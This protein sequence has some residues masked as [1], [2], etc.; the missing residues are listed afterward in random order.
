[1]HGLRPVSLSGRGCGRRVELSGR[2]GTGQLESTGAGTGQKYLYGAGIGGGSDY[3]GIQDG[4]GGHG[5]NV[6]ITGG[7][8]TAKGSENGAGIGGGR[9]GSC[10][11]VTITIAFDANGGEGEM[12]AAQPDENGEYELPESGFTAPEGMEFAGWRIGEEVEQPAEEPVEQPVEAPADA[13]KCTITFDGGGADG[14]MTAVQAALGSEFVMPECEFYLEGCT[15]DAWLVNGTLYHAGN[16]VT[17]E[18][19]MTAMASWLFDEDGEIQY[20]E[21][22]VEYGNGEDVEASADDGDNGL[23]IE[24]EDVAEEN[25]EEA[26]EGLSEEPSEV[27]SVFSGSGVAAIIAAAILALAAA[28]IAVTRRKKH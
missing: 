18:S 3:V 20:G 11:T 23:E 1:M 13:Q 25:V 9:H 6:S 7:T 24:T 21:G 16:V 28:G 26:D 10:G 2:V 15:F 17:V 12:D 27:G 19:D 8:V 14:E 5:G 22:D 4:V